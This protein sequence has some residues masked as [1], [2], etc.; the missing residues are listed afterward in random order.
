MILWHAT[1]KNNVFP[2]QMEGLRAGFDGFVYFTDSPEHALRFLNHGQT[3]EI[4]VIPVDLD[5]EEV[6]E[7]FDHNEEY[8]GCKAWIHEGDIPKDRI[9][10]SLDDILLYKINPKRRRR[11]SDRADRDEKGEQK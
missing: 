3:E 7:S 10:K 11:R 9:P 1:Q 4:A 6:E 8:F 2:I 5:P